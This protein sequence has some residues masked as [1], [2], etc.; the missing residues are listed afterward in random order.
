MRFLLSFRG[1]VLV[2]FPLALLMAT[3][4]RAVDPWSCPSSKFT[5]C[6]TRAT[7]WKLFSVPQQP[8]AKVALVVQV[9]QHASGSASSDA[10]A[11][12]GDQGDEPLRLMAEQMAR[13]MSANGVPTRYVGHVLRRAKAITLPGIDADAFVLMLFPNGSIGGNGVVDYMALLYAPGNLVQPV[14]EGLVQL[15]MKLRS[16]QDTST[17]GLVSALAEAGLFDRVGRSV[18][19]VSRFGS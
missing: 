18:V 19:P 1:L 4:A 15:D 3:D 8:I 14:F 13:V 7:P 10:L 6:P 11:S 5:L 9:F 12:T 16:I 2:A 17:K